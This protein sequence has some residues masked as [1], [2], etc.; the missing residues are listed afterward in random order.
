MS[1]PSIRARDHPRSDTFLTD[2]SSSLDASLLLSLVHCGTEEA[3]GRALVGHRDLKRVAFA[4]R[5]TQ[6]P[7]SGE[8]NSGM[9]EFA[10]AIASFIL[11]G[12]IGM[13]VVDYVSR[14]GT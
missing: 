8:R 9:T 12:T 13:L 5:A 14:R 11:V 7:A 3:S 1:K 10:T 6:K 2:S 4:L